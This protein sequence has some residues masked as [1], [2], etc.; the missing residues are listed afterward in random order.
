MWIFRF[1]FLAN[2]KTAGVLPAA[3]RVWWARWRIDAGKI[4]I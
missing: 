1:A 3:L 4:K 2:R